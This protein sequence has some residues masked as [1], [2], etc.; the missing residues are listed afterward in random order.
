ML[1]LLHERS[2]GNAFLSEEILG[3]LRDGTSLDEL[4]RTLRDVL[5]VRA[6]QLSPHAQGLLRV[7]AVAGR[8]VPD[9]LLSLV[10]ELDEASLDE[11]LREVVEHHLLSCR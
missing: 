1:A 11:A 5:L 9:Q 4:P 10:S 2:E 6:E 7:T 8:S 3:A